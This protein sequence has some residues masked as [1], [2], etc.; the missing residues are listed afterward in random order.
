VR[1]TPYYITILLAALALGPIRADSLWARR[2]PRSAFLFVDSRARRVGDLLTVIVDENT[3]I[4][5]KDERQLNKDSNAGGL[6]HFTGSTKAGNLSRDATIAFDASHS[7]TRGFDGKSQYNVDQKFLDNMTVVVIDVLP[8]GNLV[9]EGSRK[10]FVSGEERTIYVTG[11][12]R[13]N[14]IAINNSI[15]SQ[16]IGNFQIR[17]LGKGQESSFTNLGFFNRMANYFWPW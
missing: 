15:Q 16:F 11:L 9:V 7:A 6:F 2:G 4:G 13:P 3:G 10:R 14:D 12:V 8:N 5:N 17:Y 1:R